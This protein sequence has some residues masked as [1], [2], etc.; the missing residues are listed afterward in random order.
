M[1]EHQNPKDPGDGHSRRGYVSSALI[2]SS[3]TSTST[4]L[5]YQF[6]HHLCF[7][8]CNDVALTWRKPASQFILQGLGHQLHPCTLLTTSLRRI[9]A[10]PGQPASQYVDEL[11]YTHMSTL[12]IQTVTIVTSQI[13]FVLPPYSYFPTDP[14]SYIPYLIPWPQR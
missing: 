1:M 6:S 4:I 5:L 2:P 14:L 10:P 13:F 3:H 11:Y 7:L 12:H 8:K 9:N